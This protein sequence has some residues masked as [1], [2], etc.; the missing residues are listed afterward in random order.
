M[1]A[2]RAPTKPHPP[3]LPSRL[4]SDHFLWHGW[5]LALCQ[6]PGRPNWIH[7]PASVAPRATG[8]TSTPNLHLH[9]LLCL[10]TAELRSLACGRSLAPLL[11]APE[12]GP[13]Q[14]DARNRFSAPAGQ[15]Q[16][17][18]DRD[19]RRVSSNPRTGATK[20]RNPVILFLFS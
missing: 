10:S 11:L 9:H 19:P 4:T 6:P 14:R 1:N 8:Q 20:W 15:V 18:L 12:E 13:T 17:Q 16:P 3:L 2:D 7:T 5:P